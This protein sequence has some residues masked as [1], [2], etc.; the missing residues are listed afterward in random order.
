VGSLGGTGASWNGSPNITTCTPPKVHRVE[1]VGRHHRDLVDDERVDLAQQPLHVA[2]LLDR[3]VADEADR[4]LEERVDGLATDV[5]RGYARRGADH[6]LLL[7][8][9][10]EVVE[11]RRLARAGAAGDEQVLGGL[12]DRVVDRLLLLRELQRHSLTSSRFAASAS[13]V[14]SCSASRLK[15]SL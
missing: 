3:L 5:E 10:R 11:Q 14:A 2:V 9:E 12:L 1:Q 13:V 8:V 7:A 4:Q 15:R 6:E